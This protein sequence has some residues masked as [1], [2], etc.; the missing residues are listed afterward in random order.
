M[1]VASK[2]PG[3]GSLMIVP[4]KATRHEEANWR[5]TQGSSL[6][7]IGGGTTPAELDKKCH[8]DPGGISPP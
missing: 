7:I 8:I 6:N 4:Y 2:R 3:V 5:E 1:K